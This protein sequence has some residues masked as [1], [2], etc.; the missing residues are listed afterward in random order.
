MNI[1][2]NRIDHDVL[3][4]TDKCLSL[5]E[6]ELSKYQ[7]RVHKLETKYKSFVA[8]INTD[9]KLATHGGGEVEKAKSLVKNTIIPDMCIESITIRI[10]RLKEWSAQAVSL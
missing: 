9:S 6:Q 10:Q 1:K 7:K 3:A 4:G 5:I 8:T 2:L